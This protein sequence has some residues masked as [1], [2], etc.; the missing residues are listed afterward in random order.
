MAYS[1]G[2]FVSNQ[3]PATVQ[4][5][6]TDTTAILNLEL[7]KN[8]ETGETTV[9][10]V[11]YVPLLVLNRGTG[12]AD[13]YV[14][15]DVNDAMADY[16]AGDTSL[17]TADVYSKLEYALEGCHTILGEQYDTAGTPPHPRGRLTSTNPWRYRRK[18]KEVRCK[19]NGL[20]L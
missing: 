18:Q 12:V 8:F 1:L 2:N 3:S 11:S 17:V 14:I 4:V 20:L 16:N 10:N 7:T 9:T 5:N 13:Q 6:Y 19:S 15:L